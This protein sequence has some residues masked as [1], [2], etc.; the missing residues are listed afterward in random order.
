MSKIKDMDEIS[1]LLSQSEDLKDWKLEIHCPNE[2]SLVEF[3]IAV[4]VYVKDWISENMKQG[5][6][7]KH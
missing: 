7:R 6:K 5:S 2:M 1:Y 3:M 4:E